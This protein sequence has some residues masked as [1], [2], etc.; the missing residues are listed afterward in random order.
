MENL[1][2]QT[3]V[4]RCSLKP[5]AYHIVRN[6]EICLKTSKVQGVKA[7]YFLLLLKKKQIEPIHTLKCTHAI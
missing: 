6:V 7:K 2:I 5:P 3:Q 1:Y 4:Y